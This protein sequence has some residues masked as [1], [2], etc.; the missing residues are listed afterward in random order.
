MGVDLAQY[1]SIIGC[2]TA[3]ASKEGPRSRRKRRKESAKE[4]MKEAEARS[5]LRKESA[6]FWMEM[7]KISLSFS[8]SILVMLSV[9]DFGKPYYSTN[10]SPGLA[11]APLSGDFSVIQKLFLALGDVAR[12]LLVLSG[13]ETH[14]GPSY[15][16]YL[17][18]NPL[19]PDQSPYVNIYYEMGG[20]IGDFGVFFQS[21]KILTELLLQSCSC[22]TCSTCAP[23]IH[24]PDFSAK[25]VAH[26][27][28]LLT[29]GETVV[30]EW[31]ERT[32]ITQLQAALGC[33]GVSRAEKLKP[34]LLPG[35]CAACFR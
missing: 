28:Q 20:F 12:M 31:E 26:L 27:L 4:R 13:V 19:V 10:L 7:L 23:S 11:S 15:R 17:I 9:L 34:V 1:R 5:R 33:S 16:V 3:R 14:P 8:F 35:Q 30:E 6:F 21:S 18:H 25:T 24:L 2:F 22:N 29:T 32:R